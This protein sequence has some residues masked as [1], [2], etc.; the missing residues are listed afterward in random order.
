M[1]KRLS[2]AAIVIIVLCAVGL[3]RQ[4]LINPLVLLIPAAV[5]GI[6]FFLYKF[7]PERW[8][9]RFSRKSDAYK[10]RAALAKQKRRKKQRAAFRVIP[11]KKGDPPEERPKFH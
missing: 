2:Y 11:G 3:V 5:F 4:L 10:Y 9:G 1:N 8:L 7:P 6:V